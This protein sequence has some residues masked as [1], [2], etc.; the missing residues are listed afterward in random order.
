MNNLKD[1]KRKFAKLFYTIEDFF[2]KKKFLEKH[3]INSLK[4]KIKNDCEISLN[5]NQIADILIFFYKNKKNINS[6][7]KIH[8]T[9]TLEIA[10][11]LPQS[12]GFL[13][14]DDDNRYSQTLSLIDFIIDI[15]NLIPNNYI[16]KNYNHIAAPYGIVSLILNLM[17]GDFDFAFYS[18]IGLIPGVGGAISASAKIIHKIINHNK[19]VKKND[20]AKEYYKQLQSVQRVHDY[21]KDETFERTNNPYLDN[22]EENYNYNDLYADEID[23]I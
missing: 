3:Y 22:F 14:L 2:I 17:R 1:N 20:Q 15:I 18:L 6:I 5:N 21:L 12:G 11:R 13:F 7:K 10:K 19:S 9:I 23:L 4:L 8:N 16:T